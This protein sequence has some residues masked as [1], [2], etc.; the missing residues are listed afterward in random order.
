MKYQLHLYD[1]GL[2]TSSYVPFGNLVG[3]WGFNDEVVPKY[4]KTD[5]TIEDRSGYINNGAGRELN[6]I[7]V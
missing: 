5:Y 2:D 6:Y 7:P 3:Y 4:V 1:T